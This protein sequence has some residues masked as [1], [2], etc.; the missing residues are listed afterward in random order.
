M[1]DKF[2]VHLGGERG[3]TLDGGLN[4]LALSHQLELLDAAFHVVG[5]RLDLA[6]PELLQRT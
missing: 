6:L 3:L 5:G 1:L 4:V 2:F